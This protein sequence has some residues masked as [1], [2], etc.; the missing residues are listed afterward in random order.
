MVTPRCGGRPEAALPASALPA[1]EGNHHSI[2][3]SLLGWGPQVRSGAPDAAAPHA[4]PP[5]PLQLSAALQEL[6]QTSQ[7][8]DTVSQAV[9]S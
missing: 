6:Q 1:E 9:F 8:D 5:L 4:F 7:Y 2:V 3:G